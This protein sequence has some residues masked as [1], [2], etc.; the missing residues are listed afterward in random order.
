LKTRVHLTKDS[1][2]TTFVGV[3]FDNNRGMG[4][5]GMGKEKEKEKK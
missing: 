2:V 1:G 4:G 5:K 3:T